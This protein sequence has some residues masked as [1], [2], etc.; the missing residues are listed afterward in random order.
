M[1]D[2]VPFVRNG[3][4]MAMS[5]VLMQETEARN[6][7]V[8]EF[9]D[10]LMANAGDKHQPSIAKIGA[11][12]GLGLLNAG[13]RNMSISLR[14][15]VGFELTAAVVGAAIF[16]QSWYW[17]PLMHF[18]SLAF[19]PTAVIGVNTDLLIPTNW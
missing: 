8:K 19:K 3:A 7:Y 13:G 17:Y 11:I 15:S 1:G 10:K 16:M 14:S 4:V 18:I 6:P 2:G 12:M 5:M 9:G